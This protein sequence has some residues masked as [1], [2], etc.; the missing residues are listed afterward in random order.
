M[1]RIVLLVITSVLAGLLLVDMGALASPINKNV[2]LKSTNLPIVWLTADGTMN[3]DERITARMKIIDNGTGQLNYTDT[4]AHPGQHVDYDGYIAIRYRG[5]S[6]YTHSMKK[7]Y[8]FRPLDKPLEEGGSWKKVPMLGMPKDN[9]W[10]LLAPFSDRS[11]IRDMDGIH[12]A[13]ALLRGH[14]Q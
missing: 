14:I 4:I 12:T 2:K 3:H 1:K 13:R 7:P 11:M 5:N 8:S 6:S 9:N 10:A